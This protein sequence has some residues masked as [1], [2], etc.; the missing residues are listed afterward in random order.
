MR[1]APRQFRRAATLSPARMEAA[2]AARV[3]P[4]GLI[5]TSKG[6]GGANG[7]CSA[8]HVEAGTTRVRRFDAAGG[9]RVRR[10]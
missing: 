4:S 10:A 7:N 5:S 8:Q 3:F 9:E 2:T 1:Q 6:G